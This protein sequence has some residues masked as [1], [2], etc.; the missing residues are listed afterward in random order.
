[1]ELSTWAPA[2]AR[3]LGVLDTGTEL[4]LGPHPEEHR[5]ILDFGNRRVRM[6]LSEGIAL[7][8]LILLG[9]VLLALATRRELKVRRA[10]DRFLAGATHDLKTPLAT[11]QLGLQTLAAGKLES[12]KATRYLE[13]MQAETY[14]L[15]SRLNDLLLAAEIGGGGTRL[16]QSPSDLHTEVTAVLEEMA[17]RFASQGFTVRA[18]PIEPVRGTFD[19]HAIRIITRN[20]LDNA[21]KYSG[22]NRRIELSLT[23]AGNIATLQVR[24]FGIGV[25]GA[26]RNLIFDRFYR[27]RSE[28]ATSAGGTGL[29]LF[30][31][32]E[33]VTAHGGTVACDSAGPG[34]GSSF[35]VELPVANGVA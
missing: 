24:D 35:V 5:R 1:V 30:L 28:P 14:K 20:L 6:F 13:A 19:P 17:P 27:S 23:K 10:Q 32:R 18:E 25:D 15:E 8:A 3:A 31:V 21:V 7:T 16:H 2:A 22:D 34:Q 29:G 9:V 33:L 26:E 4:W 11:I 12:A